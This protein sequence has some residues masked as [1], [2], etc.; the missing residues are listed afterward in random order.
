MIMLLVAVKWVVNI[1]HNWGTMTYSSES[2][3]RPTLNYV[4]KGDAITA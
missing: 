3:T 1:V 2:F 4:L